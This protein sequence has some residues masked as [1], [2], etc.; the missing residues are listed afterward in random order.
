MIYMGGLIY[1]M[2]MLMLLIFYKAA[3]QRMHADVTI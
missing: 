2:H 1:Y 3:L